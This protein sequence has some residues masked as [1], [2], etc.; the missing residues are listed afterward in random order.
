MEDDT[1]KVRIYKNRYVEAAT[2]SDALP[3]TPS[4]A[5]DEDLQS[6]NEALRAGQ[7]RMHLGM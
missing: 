1:T 6:E 2:P 3:A 5:E 7:P 4:D